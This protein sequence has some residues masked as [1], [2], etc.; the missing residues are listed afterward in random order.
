MVSVRASSAWLTLANP[1][2]MLG[3]SFCKLVDVGSVV[4]F[5]EETEE[6]QIDDSD[7]ETIS[8]PVPLTPP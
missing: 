5:S 8:S 2:K 7:T 4:I 3:F 6:E 1:I